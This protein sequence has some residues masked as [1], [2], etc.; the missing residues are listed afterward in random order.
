MEAC[1][2][3]RDLI[4]SCISPPCPGPAATQPTQYVAHLSHFK[5]HARHDHD[6]QKE[7]LLEEFFIQAEKSVPLSAAAQ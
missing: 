7:G 5:L 6:L 1:C 4:K 2:P 3:Q